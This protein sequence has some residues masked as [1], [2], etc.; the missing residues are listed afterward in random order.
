MTILIFS[1]LIVLVIIYAVFFLLCK[2]GWLIFKS[3][4]NKGPLITAGICTGLTALVIGLGIWM[5]VNAVKAPFR[6]MINRVKQNAAPVYGARTYQDDAFPFTLTVYD[7]MDFSDWITWGRV[8]FKLGID[9]NAF[10]KDA[11]GQTPKKFL[12]SGIV[13]YPLADNLHSLDALNTQLQEAQAQHRLTLTSSGLSEI[14]GLP[15]YRAQGEA[16][17]NRGKIYFWLAVV[18]TNSG[19]LYYLGAISAQEDPTLQNQANAMLSSFKVV[20]TN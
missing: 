8:K 1:A 16:Y 15:A 5:G 10:K 13:R 7:G 3:P 14:N 20:P 11:S 17:T 2:I 6:G 12:M 4:S 18:Q 9:T 19:A